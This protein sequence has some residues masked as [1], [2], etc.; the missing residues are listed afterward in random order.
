MFLVFFEEKFFCEGKS[1][2]EYNIVPHDQNC[3][4]K[5]FLS[6]IFHPC[7]IKC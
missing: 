7:Q 6:Q 4:N 2:M 3:E 5:F 1:V